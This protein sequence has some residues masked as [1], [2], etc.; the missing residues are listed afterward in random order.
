MI[1]ANCHGLDRTVFHP[2]HK[3]DV[4]FNQYEPKDQKAPFATLLTAHRNVHSRFFS[5][6]LLANFT[7]KSTFKGVL[8]LLNSSFHH[9]IALL[10][11]LEPNKHA[12]RSL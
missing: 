6:S 5:T 12:N 4:Q 7:K 9:G 1:L 2:S 11:H 10:Q 8:Q 3:N